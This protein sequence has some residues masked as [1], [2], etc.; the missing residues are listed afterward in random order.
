MPDQVNGLLSPWLR[1]RRVNMIKPYLEGKILDIGCGVGYLSEFVPKNLYYGMDIDEVS[2][3][4]AHKRYPGVRFESKYPE[5]EQFETIVLLAVIEHV[6]DPTYFLKQLKSLLVP[7]GRILLTTPNS[8]LNSV[9]FLGSKTWL[10]SQE[11]RQEHKHLFDYQSMEELVSG[12]ELTIHDYKRF[13]F[14]ANQ[15]FILKHK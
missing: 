15:L 9:L 1:R 4:I 14:G 3:E 6:D 8:L 11:A 2:L 5:G 13:L 12:I 7:S 10:F